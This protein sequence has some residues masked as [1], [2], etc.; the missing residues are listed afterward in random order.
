M[1]GWDGAESGGKRS[2][3]A[4]VPK[5]VIRAQRRRIAHTKSP[6]WSVP[7]TSLAQGARRGA[8]ARQ[9]AFLMPVRG[10]RWRY[11]AQHAPR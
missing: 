7:H 6:K 9:D 10:E 8:D 5:D 2:L 11:Q 1:V 4:S 3:R